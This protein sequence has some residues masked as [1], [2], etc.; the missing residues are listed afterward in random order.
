MSR[1]DK[2]PEIKGFYVIIDD[3]SIRT[4]NKVQSMIEKKKEIWMYSP[5]SLFP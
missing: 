5:S 4:S 3:A 2:F 1:M